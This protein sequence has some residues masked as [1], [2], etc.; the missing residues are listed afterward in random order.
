MQR[1]QIVIVDLHHVLVVRLR[2]SD[3]LSLALNCIGLV[4]RVIALGR[5]LADHV[6]DQLVHAV[7]FM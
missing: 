5:A 7:T 4:T 6:V 2:R 3:T 1:T